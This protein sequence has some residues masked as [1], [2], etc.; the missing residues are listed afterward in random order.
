MKRKDKPLRPDPT[1]ANYKGN[2]GKNPVVKIT[3]VTKPLKK[4]TVKNPSA[5][6]ASAPR[7]GG[8]RVITKT[9]SA[10]R[11]DK[12]RVAKTG[13][14]PITRTITDSKKSGKKSYPK[15]GEFQKLYDSDQTLTKKGYVPLT[16]AEKRAANEKMKSKG[17]TPPKKKTPPAS[18]PP[19]KS[20]LSK[21]RGRGGGVGGVGGSGG[22]Y[23]NMFKR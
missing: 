9:E 4:A 10:I 8:V 13:Q 1:K 18:K 14:L 5:P 20:V 16:A 21:F 12:A 22:L 23:G 2:T 15:R 17:V 7:G 11:R 6:S 19:K 3:K